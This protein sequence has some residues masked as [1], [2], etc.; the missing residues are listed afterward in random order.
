MA[1]HWTIDGG[2]TSWSEW[3]D[4][5]AQSTASPLAEELLAKRHTNLKKL[6]LDIG[7]GTGRAFL[8]LQQA[9]FE[10]VGLDA[11]MTGL[12]VC[13]SHLVRDH[14]TASLICTSAAQLP[15]QSSSIDLILALGVLFHLGPGELEM[16]L[17]SIRRVMK[18]EGEAILHFLD[19]QDWRKSLAR[20]IAPE[21]IPTPSYQA[22]VT[23]FCSRDIL[24]KSLLASGLKITSLELRTKN[25]ERG[26]QYDW[27]ACCLRE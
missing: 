11:I 25:T 1:V 16:A 17:Q 10:V 3:A 21:E 15:L 5:M 23:S 4:A 24:E 13:Q 7:C 27:V 2:K 22:V 26:L 8:P 20:T 9:G 14:F 6:A 18:P 19:I 12:R